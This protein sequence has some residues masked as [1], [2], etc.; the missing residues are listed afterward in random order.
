MKFRVPKNFFK[1]KTIFITGGTGSFGKNMVSYLIK[2]HK[3][4]KKIIIYSRDELKQFEMASNYSSLENEKLR[5]FIGDVRDKERLKIAME[6]V[7]YVFH[8]AALKQVPSSEY[9]PFETVKTNIIGSQNV[10]EIALENNIEKVLALSTDKASSPYNLYGATKLCA[11]KLFI[12][13][14][15]VSGNRKISFSVLRYGNVFG[16]RGSVIETFLKSKNNN[17]FNITDKRMTRFN[18]TIKEAIERAVYSL[19]ISQGEEI[20][21]PKLPSYRILDLAKAISPKAKLNI[22]GIRPGEKI[23]EELISQNNAINTV[24]IKYFY[25]ILKDKFGNIAKNYKKKHNSKN[26]KNNFSYTSNNNEN[27]LSINQIKKLL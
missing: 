27:F 13:A 21:I 11:D 22:I 17:I 24:E 14:N 25:I 26:V 18:I 15:N 7:N 2:N 16:S 6:N 3:N 5:F 9:N 23:N 1:N 8:A 10:I 19:Y 4:L 20:I 12:A